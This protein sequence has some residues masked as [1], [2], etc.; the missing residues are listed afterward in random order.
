M[1]LHTGIL[2]LNMTVLMGII[3]SGIFTF[4]AI[5]PAPG[6]LA[7][8]ASRFGTTYLLV[9]P[10]VLIVAPIAQRLTRWLIEQLSPA[11]ATPAELSTNTR[12]KTISYITEGHHLSAGDDDHAEK[13]CH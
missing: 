12:A 6:F 10:T 9:L 1:T 8:W 13:H 4:Q 7:A 5:G 11:L 2:M 3:L